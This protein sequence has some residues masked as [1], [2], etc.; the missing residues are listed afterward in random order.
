MRAVTT[1]LGRNIHPRAV[2]NALGFLALAVLRIR[3]YDSHAVI[4]VGI[5]EP[6]QMAGY[7]R[8]VRPDITVVTSIGSEHNRSLKTL[9]V[10]RS[11][12]AEMVRI[13]PSSGLAVLNGD[14]PNVLWMRSQSCARVITFGF[15]ESNDVRAS[16]LTLDWPTGSRFTLHAGG[17]RRIVRTRLIGKHMVYPFLAAVAVSLA[18][19]LTLDQ[20]IPALEALPPT[21]GCMEPVVLPNGAIILRDEFK[22][23]LETIDA[24]L[25][26]FSEIPARRRIVVL[27]EVS[28]PPGSQGPIYRRFGERI[29]KVASR[30]I[31]VGHRSSRKPVSIGVK[32][33]GLPREEF[34]DAGESV[35]KAVEALRADLGPGDV[36]LIKGRTNQ[37]LDRVSLL[38]QG[39]AVRCHLRV[40]DAKVRCDKCP[41][42]EQG[43]NGLRDAM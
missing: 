15:A 9:D 7:A 12:K 17:E 22:S 37:R 8:L 20:V 10:T 2:L 31:F 40:C 23:T 38:L 35:S 26:T 39:R 1:A 18:E 4:E 11:E 5:G 33:A 42:L 30:A 25:D 36:V 32:R 24:A 34:I 21:P 28:E 27:G 19:G 16:E 3:P 13:L 14:D 29:G 41:M 43:W 6:G